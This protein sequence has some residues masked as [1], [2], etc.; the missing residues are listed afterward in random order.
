MTN[1]VPEWIEILKK[2]D[3][4]VVVFPYYGDAV[5]AEVVENN[6]TSF[7]SMYFGTITINYTI[8]NFAKQDDL[9]YD[10]YSKEGDHRDNWYAYQV[11]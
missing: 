8:N 4:F 1:K 11:T 6:P 9:L 2:G 3:F 7:D 10:D 5:F